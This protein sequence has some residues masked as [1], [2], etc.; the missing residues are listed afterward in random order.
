VITPEDQAR[1][2]ID[3]LLTAAEWAV[4]DFKQA[5]IHAKAIVATLRRQLSGQTQLRLFPN[6]TARSFLQ[7]SVEFR[8]L[9]S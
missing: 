7:R 9:V 6:A 3:A 4:Q 2:N 8:R 5:N 1:Q